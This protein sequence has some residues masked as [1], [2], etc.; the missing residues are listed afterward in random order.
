[1]A[2]KKVGR[3]PGHHAIPEGYSKIMQWCF[4]NSISI[5]VVPDW[6]RGP[7]WWVVEVRI[8]KKTH[9]DPG[10]YLVKEAYKKMFNYYKYYYDKYNKI[11]K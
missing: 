7:E 6:S 11:S 4:K 9:T 2:K 8:N 1:M 3:S 5:A 10:S